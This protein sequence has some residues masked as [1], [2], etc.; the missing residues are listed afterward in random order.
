MELIVWL[1]WF[2]Y[3]HVSDTLSCPHSSKH[4]VRE[5]MA[6]QKGEE[7]ILIKDFKGSLIKKINIDVHR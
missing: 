4:V 1:L 5:E 2:C 3:C 7:V 6:L